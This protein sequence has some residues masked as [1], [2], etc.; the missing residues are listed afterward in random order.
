MANIGVD[1]AGLEAVKAEARMLGRVERTQRM[2]LAAALAAVG[3]VV[4]AGAMMANW[5]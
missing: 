2:L 4:V 5:F 1:K 3:I